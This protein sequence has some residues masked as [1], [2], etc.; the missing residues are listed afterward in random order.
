MAEAQPPPTAAGGPPLPA[1]SPL[2]PGAGQWKSMPKLPSW[3]TPAWSTG[4]GGIGGT[5]ANNGTPGGARRGP[6]SHGMHAVRQP[7]PTAMSMSHLPELDRLGGWGSSSSTTEPSL[8][9]GQHQ[10][11]R[12]QQAEEKVGGVLGTMSL[13]SLLDSGAKL[14]GSVE[15]QASSQGDGAAGGG[16][17][18]SGSMSGTRTDGMI[19]KQLTDLAMMQQQQLQKQLEQLKSQ[20]KKIE[21]LR[22]ELHL[23]KDSR[24]RQAL[25]LQQLSHT[26][27]H[28]QM[29]PSQQSD[30]SSGGGGGGS[31]GR[32]GDGSGRG[33]AGDGDEVSSSQ[34]HSPS[35]G[36]RYYPPP[37]HQPYSGGGPHD[38]NGV[39]HNPNYPAMGYDGMPYMD[40]RGSMR[41]VPVGYGMGYGGM[42]HP[43]AHGV[44][45]QFRDMIM[46]GAMPPMPGSGNPYMA[47]APHQMMAP[48][49]QRLEFNTSTGEWVEIGNVARNGSVGNF[50]DGRQSGSN[51]DFHRSNA[52]RN[53]GQNKRGGNN[54]DSGTV[55]NKKRQGGGGNRRGG[56]NQTSIVSMEKIRAGEEQR[57]TLMIRNI[58]NR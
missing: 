24:R 9:S 30:S 44:P 56:R 50:D 55:G 10:G 53:Q 16:S 40:P 17:S 18:D 54:W 38:P 47:G 21:E 1:P 4:A 2:Q 5:A 35:G 33:G 57:T 12:L 25:L 52:N 46:G 26:Q 45:Q 58:P 8:G 34:P 29:Q 43:G 27:A 51:S 13:E 32:R 7:P 22:E 11:Q 14:L 15:A 42:M 3:E 37:Q 41:Q 49:P 23:E 6:D 28:M 39:T 31:N 36:G 19:Q 20:R 48:L